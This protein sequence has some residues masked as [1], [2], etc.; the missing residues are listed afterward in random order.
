MA[1]V[2]N[3]AYDIWWA[4]VDPRHND[5]RTKI[6]GNDNHLSLVYP[7]V[8]T[9]IIFII[10]MTTDELMIWFGWNTGNAPAP[11]QGNAV[12]DGYNVY[13]YTETS[14]NGNTRF[15]FFLFF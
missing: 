13:D 7:F 6:T 8:L 4:S 10:I 12:N 14:L 2:W 3:M 11:V 1:K 5:A 9:K 15:F